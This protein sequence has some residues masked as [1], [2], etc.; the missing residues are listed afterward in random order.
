MPFVEKKLDEFL[1]ASQ[2]SWRQGEDN[3]EFRIANLRISL[4]IAD[5]GLMD[6]D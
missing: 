4:M 1:A 6:E 5:P 3:C 2:A